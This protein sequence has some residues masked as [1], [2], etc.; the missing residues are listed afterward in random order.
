MKIIAARGALA[1]GMVLALAAPLAQAAGVTSC[2]DSLATDNP[3][4]NA[5]ATTFC[6]GPLDGAF[7]AAP[8]LA[9]LAVLNAQF[10]PDMW[11]RLG[12]SGGFSD[13]F[14]GFTGGLPG[15]TLSLKPFNADHF[16]LGLQAL[17]E[18]SISAI[19]FYEFD[20]TGLL[21]KNLITYD[22]RGIDVTRSPFSSLQAAA[23]YVPLGTGG[24]GGTV[25]EPASWALAFMALA[26]L[27][28][29]TARRR[30]DTR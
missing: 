2:T 21:G 16:I 12:V 17:G 22:T 6:F 27:G 10:G 3:V 14:V 11:Q 29:T 19:S 13:P 7:G 9:E 26:A 4:V 25:P 30:S 23:L 8:G 24:G 28:Y 18:S 5:G 20:Y 1:L 15:G